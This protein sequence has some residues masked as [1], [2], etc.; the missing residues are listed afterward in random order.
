M[1]MIEFKKFRTERGGGG[2]GVG[3]LHVYLIPI[4]TKLTYNA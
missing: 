3:D 1:S 4:C 2:G